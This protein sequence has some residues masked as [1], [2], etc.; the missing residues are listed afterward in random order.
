M[1]MAHQRGLPPASSRL[2]SSFTFE[3]FT[4]E[5]PGWNFSCLCATLPPFHIYQWNKSDRSHIWRKVWPREG[6]YLECC[7]HRGC[8]H[9]HLSYFTCFL[10][11]LVCFCTRSCAMALSHWHWNASSYSFSVSH[12]IYGVAFFYCLEDAFMWNDNLSVT[13]LLPIVTTQDMTHIK[14]YR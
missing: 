5:I 12:S 9:H 1:G 14:F 4:G 13:W 2:P 7:P 10:L 6:G 11:P 8:W 3:S